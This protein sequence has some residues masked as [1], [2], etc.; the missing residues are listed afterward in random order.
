LQAIATLSVE[1][2]VE[3]PNHV[4]NIFATNSL[5]HESIAH[6]TEYAQKLQTLKDV[7]VDQIM[8]MATE[9]TRVWCL[10]DLARTRQDFMRVH[11]TL[12]AAVIESCAK[13]T[14]QLVSMRAQRLP[15]LI[16]E[17]EMRIEQLLSTLHV[18]QPWAERA[19]DF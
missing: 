5:S 12:S 14:E 4:V 3:I 6:V 15:A 10:L 16:R 9:I 2:A 11:S 18:I 1:L 13:E 7:R 17:Q 19:D 8:T